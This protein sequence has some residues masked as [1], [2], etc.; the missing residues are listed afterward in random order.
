M[1]ETVVL[2]TQV[3]TAA[4]S[5]RRARNTVLLLAASVAIVATGFGI[6]MPVFARRV[7]EFGSGVETLGLMTMSFALAAFLAAPLMGFLADR[8]GRRP[9][10]LNWPQGENYIKLDP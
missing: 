7:G 10:I 4:P 8:I 2:A 9:L 3:V 6:V 1:L 5:A